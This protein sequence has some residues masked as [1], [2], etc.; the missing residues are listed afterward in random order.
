MGI[1]LTPTSNAYHIKYVDYSKDLYPMMWEEGMFFSMTGDDT[2]HEAYRL[3]LE[4]FEFENNR[5]VEEALRGD[6]DGWY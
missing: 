5:W 3:D 1:S 4:D 6:D 2:V